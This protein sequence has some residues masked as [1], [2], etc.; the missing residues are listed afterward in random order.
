MFIS[1]KVLVTCG[2]LFLS[3]VFIWLGYTMGSANNKE[4]AVPA[5]A[6]ATPTTTPA[7]ETTA[8]KS[9]GQSAKA[10]ISSWNASSE[11]QITSPITT[12]EEQD[13]IQQ[14][15]D[16]AFGLI[17]AVNKS[18]QTL[19]NV[20]IITLRGSDVSEG[21]TVYQAW[22]ALIKSTN[23][24][25]TDKQVAEAVKQI[26]DEANKNQAG[27]K[28]FIHTNVRYV[29]QMDE[30]TGIWLIAE[31]V[32]EEEQE[33]N[34]NEAETALE[35]LKEERSGFDAAAIMDKDL[36]DLAAA[37]K[38]KG[39]PFG[40]GAT[41]EEVIEKLGT[42]GDPDDIQW[43]YKDLLTY[44]QVSYLLEGN[45]VVGLQIS[46]NNEVWL[47]PFEEVLD[48]V[49]KDGSY[50]DREWVYKQFELDG[51]A[52]Y[53]VQSDL[54]PNYDYVILYKAAKPI[55][56]TE[57]AKK[58]TESWPRYQNVRFGFSIAYSKNWTMGV[59]ADN[60]DGV[61]FS[62]PSGGKLLAYASF[63]MEEF[64][65]DLMGYTLL[66]LDNGLKVHLL[67]KE[68]AGTTSIEMYYVKDSRIEY[69]VSGTVSQSYFKKNEKEIISMIKSV[70]FFEGIEG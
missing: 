68:E 62:E 58:E 61:S 25:L 51:Y 12:G 35:V 5:A 7:A 56:K 42:S 48:Q 33:S 13:V 50:T 29:L 30:V 6:T 70:N 60:G 11:Y 67:V 1:K 20:I 47:R 32:R 18:D 9:L 19:R 16:D 55:E 69:H 59:E 54:N 57:E 38:L 17:A 3:I 43:L 28:E 40:I 26:A 46:V 39:V 53:L 23:P 52:L 24:S 22:M 65:P 49:A 10:F 8:F 66:V 64:A 41:K 44:D 31:N 45:K 63:Y 34:T 2:L 14:V 15:F 36:P 4:A 27:E 37:G 21:S